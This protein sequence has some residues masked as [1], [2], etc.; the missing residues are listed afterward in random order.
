MSSSVPHPSH[1]PLV[2][3]TTADVTGGLALCLTFGCPSLSTPQRLYTSSSSPSSHS[4]ATL[5]EM[6]GHPL[7]S[8]SPE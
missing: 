7:L 8:A 3:A 4:A 1:N 5:S 6:D 2:A